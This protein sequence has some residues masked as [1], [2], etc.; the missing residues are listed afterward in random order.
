LEG[1]D[2]LFA[3]IVTRSLWL[4]RNAVVFGREFTAPA[5]LVVE[6]QVMMRDFLKA[7]V[8]KGKLYGLKTSP[9]VKWVPPPCG[10][11]KIKWD[12]ALDPR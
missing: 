10:F 12:T 7:T 11:V 4:R 6:A 9:V 8:I 1:E 3:L 5:S 2:L